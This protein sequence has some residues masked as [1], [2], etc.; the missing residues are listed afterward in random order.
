MPGYPVNEEVADAIERVATVLESMGHIVEQAAPDYDFDAVIEAFTTVW[1]VGY[2]DLIQQSALAMGRRLD[3]QTL[4]PMTLAVLEAARDTPPAK[5]PG[6]IDYFNR[7][8]RTF[9]QFFTNYDIWLTPA[10]AQPSEP[11]GKYGQNLEGM[12]GE[13]YIRLTERP[14]QFAVPYNVTGFPAISAA[15]GGNNGRT[16]D[17]HSV[18][19][20]AQQ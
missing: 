16:A 10:T 12:T 14:V 6:A 17:R 7:V 15:V 9:G 13:E 2:D 5:L 18:G 4:E 11:W 3:E 19:C 20:G 1:F 8:R